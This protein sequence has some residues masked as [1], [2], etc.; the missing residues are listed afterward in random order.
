[1]PQLRQLPFAL[2]CLSEGEE[3]HMVPRED[4]V[5]ERSPSAGGGTGAWLDDA[6]AVEGAP[7]PSLHDLERRYIA[8]VL[9]EARGNQRQAAPILGISRRSLSRR[10]R[11]Y[12]LPPRTA[13]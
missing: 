5:P 12:G 11:K 6:M 1:M 10:L 7:L 8:R 3:F 2:P 4:E 13:A 9:E